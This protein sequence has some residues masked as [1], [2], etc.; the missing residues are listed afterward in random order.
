MWPERRGGVAGTDPADRGMVREPGAES[1]GVV[2]GPG[3][4]GGESRAVGSCD[5]QQR[6]GACMCERGLTCFAGGP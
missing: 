3:A 4:D 5:E 1:R 2:C 6:D